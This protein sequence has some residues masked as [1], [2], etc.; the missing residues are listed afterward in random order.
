MRAWRGLGRDV[1]DTGKVDEPVLP[2]LCL[3]T[4]FRDTMVNIF[5][6]QRRLVEGRIRRRVQIEEQ[7]S[8]VSS[9]YEKADD[10]GKNNPS[11]LG[12]CNRTTALNNSH[13]NQARI[14]FTLASPPQYMKQISLTTLLAHTRPHTKHGSP[15][16]HD[17][18]P[19]IRLL[20]DEQWAD[21][22]YDDDDVGCDVKQERRDEVAEG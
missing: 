16:T 5:G 9:S 17:D 21:G 22:E 20:V 19:D 1:I 3:S 13:R 18:T 14:N 11:A 12:R 15:S 4:L 10:T 2:G 7:L 8:C 6:V